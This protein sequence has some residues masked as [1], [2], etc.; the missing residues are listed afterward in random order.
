MRL[1]QIDLGK[2][3]VA[4]EPLFREGTDGWH[5]AEAIPDLVCVVRGGKITFTNSG[6]V[7]LLGAD[8]PWDL[9]GTRLE[10]LLAPEYRPLAENGYK[11][12][13]EEWEPLPIRLIR[14]DGKGLD[15]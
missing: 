3:A 13:L 10:D 14:L 9:A 15:V 1:E 4:V 2:A 7:R 11:Q 5:L 8:T 12:W 6:G